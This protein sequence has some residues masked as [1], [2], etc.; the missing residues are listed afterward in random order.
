ML[1]RHIS[2]NKIREMS[3]PW[4][5]GVPFCTSARQPQ[6]VGA[7]ATPLEDRSSLTS[8]K[9]IEVSRPLVSSASYIGPLRCGVK[10]ECSTD[11]E[12]PFGGGFLTRTLG[13]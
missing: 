10:A 11:G 1:D 3:D 7:Q 12:K 13:L 5:W 9:L 4:S 8:L 6:A 2:P